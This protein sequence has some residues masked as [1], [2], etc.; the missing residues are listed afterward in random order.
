MNWTGREIVTNSYVNIAVKQSCIITCVVNIQP[1]VRRTSSD[2]VW[3]C[4]CEVVFTAMVLQNVR[5]AA[6]NLRT[7]VVS[8]F[9]LIHLSYIM[10]LS[11]CWIIRPKLH[12]ILIDSNLSLDE[13]LKLIY[14]VSSGNK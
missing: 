5:T 14:I 7:V 10:F 12:V 9:N 11:F 4:V 13:T 1:T 2:V 8:C 3:D 6:T